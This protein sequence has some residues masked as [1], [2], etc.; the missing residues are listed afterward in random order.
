MSTAPPAMTAPPGVLPKEPVSE[1][2]G[3]RRVECRPEQPEPTLGEVRSRLSLELQVN[4]ET[5]QIRIED[6]T[7]STATART[8]DG[9]I[10]W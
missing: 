7:D 3:G 2:M 8:R 5:I 1:L 6:V 4:S 10:Q 9:P